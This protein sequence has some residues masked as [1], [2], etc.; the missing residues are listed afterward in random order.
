[1]NINIYRDFQISIR[2]PLKDSISQYLQLERIFNERMFI[3]GQNVSE[4]TR[5]K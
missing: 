5:A 4:K 1:M 2:V 3:N